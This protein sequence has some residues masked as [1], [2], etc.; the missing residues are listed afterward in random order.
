MNTDITYHIGK[1]E[2]PAI[3]FI[4]GLAI[5]KAIWINPS[6]C[7][8]FSGLLPITA[9]LSIRPPEQDFGVSRRRPGPVFPGLTTG[10]YPETL[11][12]LFDDILSSG[13]TVAT[14]SQKRPVG[15][16]DAAV[17]ELGEV[18]NYV[19]AQHKNSIILVGHSR[20]GLIARKYLMHGD[21][22]V[23]GLVTVSTPHQGSSIA[24]LAVYLSPLAPLIAPLLTQV[25]TRGML[26]KA[27][28]RTHDLLASK[29]A[30][31]L[32]PDSDF[33][34]SLHDT[35]LKNVRYMTIGGTN[36]ALFSVYRWKW[37]TSGTGEK[38]KWL[39]CP[40]TILSVPDIFEKIIPKKIY[41]LELKKNR[42]DGIV[43]AESSSIPWCDNHH[44]VPCNHA[45]VLFD[46]KVR[47]MVREFIE[48]ID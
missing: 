6:E 29:A 12:T 3:L 36:P 44:L 39:L 26:K 24:R 46:K 22:R 15:E 34:R 8:M 17:I 2:R 18:I 23:K 40:E 43:S 33:F 19:S 37:K 14:W 30:N 7:T 41:P 9:L 38:K 48:E 25:K 35:K 42:G 13:Y 5:D 45:G 32:L 47:K 4:H 27:L 20:G 21:D 10:S 28:K 16:I 31:E 11:T 1:K